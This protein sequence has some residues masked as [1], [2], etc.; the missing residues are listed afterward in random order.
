MI[1]GCVLRGYAITRPQVVGSLAQESAWPC[2]D[3]HTITDISYNIPCRRFKPRPL[4]PVY[5]EPL[6]IT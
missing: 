5:T 2:N 6:Q 1:A 4:K 3:S